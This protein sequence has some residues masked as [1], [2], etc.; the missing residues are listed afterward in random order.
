[1]VSGEEAGLKSDAEG[2]CL[3]L[4]MKDWKN[5]RRNTIEGFIVGLVRIDESIKKKS[6]EPKLDHSFKDS[7]PM[8]YHI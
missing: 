2:C 4:M 1:M 3:M 5:E 7:Y 8:M 6:I